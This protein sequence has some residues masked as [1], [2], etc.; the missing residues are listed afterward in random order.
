MP[1]NRK[2]YC[3]LGALFL[4]AFL[5]YP[6]SFTA[7]PEM[8]VLILDENGKVVPGAVV[9]EKWEYQRIGSLEH[10]EVFTADKDSYAIFPKRTDRIPLILL[11]P[12]I[13]REII[14]LPHGYGFGSVFTIF[15]YGKD[16]FEW[17]YI[18]LSSY[19]TIPRELRLK[20]HDEIRFPNDGK[21][22]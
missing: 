17:E 12:S 14:H 7:A 18:P 6:W 1:T 8:R 20:R 4:L 10:R 5:L 21:W 3:V 9:Q 2:I 19:E 15:A 13:A 22:P 11:I 16:L